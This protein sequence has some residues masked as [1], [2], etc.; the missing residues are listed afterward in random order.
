MAKKV[1]RKISELP[2]KEGTDKIKAPDEAHV[3][4]P[5]YVERRVKRAEKRR[6]PHV[7]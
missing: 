1:Y 3:N 6:P 4:D 2:R 5:A 7:K